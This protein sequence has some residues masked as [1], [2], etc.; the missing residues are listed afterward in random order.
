MLL[1]GDMNLWF[2]DT[3]ELETKI[4]ENSSRGAT[5]TKLTMDKKSLLAGKSE[6]P[7]Y[8]DEHLNMIFDF[9]QKNNLATAGHIHPNSGFDRALQYGIGS[10]EHS[11]ADA[12]LTEK[13]VAA[14]AKKEDCHCSNHD[15]CA[16]AGRGGSVR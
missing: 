14:M 9:A 16:D 8:A 5:L 10:M 2:K 13:E 3:K 11:I 4:R 6:I 7:V 15:Y 12:V 1:T